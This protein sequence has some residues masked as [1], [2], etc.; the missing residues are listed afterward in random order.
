VT[1]L[2]S[3]AR[4]RLSWRCCARAWRLFCQRVALYSAGRLFWQLRLSSHTSATRGCG[5]SL[6]LRTLFLLCSVTFRLYKHHLIHSSDHFSTKTRSVNILERQSIRCNHNAFQHSAPTTLFT[7]LN[8]FLYSQHTVMDPIAPYP[9][10]LVPR[11]CRNHTRFA[12]SYDIRFH[13]LGRL[14]SHLLLHLDS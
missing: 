4:R 7:F 10:L 5:L 14:V 6:P 3:Q 11:S 2:C 9:R 13:H 1:L 8:Q 12:I